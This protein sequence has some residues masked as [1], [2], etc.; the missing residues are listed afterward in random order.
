VSK[1]CSILR[2]WLPIATAV[3]GLCGLVY[4]AVQQEL[5]QSANDPQIQLAQDAADALA[6]GGAADG[7][8]PRSE[9]DVARSLAPF[10]IAY[11][12]QGE[13]VASSGILHGQIPSL[14]A[15]V[16]DYVRENSEDRVTWQPEAGVRIAAVIVRFEG[17]ESGFVL[18]GRSL[19]EIE[20]RETQVE[21]EA[22]LALA[23]TLAATLVVVG[24][25]DLFLSDRRTEAR[26]PLK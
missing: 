26:P 24:L 13:A 3:T 18:A 5:R 15:G 16:L 20:K 12:D 6:R 14:P 17:A 7:V 23:A 10:M 11:D 9:I 19:R 25:F 2:H 4:L 22:G 8:V 1:A 21:L